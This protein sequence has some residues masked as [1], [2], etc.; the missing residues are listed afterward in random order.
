ME[1][2][3]GTKV[4][5][6][7]KLIECIKNKK[8]ENFKGIITTSS[9]HSPQGVI[10]ANEAIAIGKPSIVCVG[11]NKKAFEK[12]KLNHLPLRL[13]EEVGAEIINVAGTG[14]NS[15]LEARAKTLAEENKYDL[16]N[17]GINMNSYPEAI[18][19]SVADQ[20]KNLPDNLDNIIVPCGS[21]ITFAG[22]MVG[23]EKY[24]KKEKRIIGCQI[25]GYDRSKEINKILDIFNLKK[26]YELFIDKTYPYIKNV[27]FKISQDFELNVKY[28]SKAFQYFLLHR[29][30]M[31]INK[32]DKSLFWTIANN[33]FL[34]Y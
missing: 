12:S 16:I 3:G 11:I 7:K 34:Y 15:V 9:V 25:S 8:K 27:D 24:N 32:N 28:E 1:N 5:Q 23:L 4:R 33:N 29:N 17:F 20:V 22:I 26:Q 18:I 31:G 19:T 10:V 13:A 30:K 6:I 2:L 14:F 21:G